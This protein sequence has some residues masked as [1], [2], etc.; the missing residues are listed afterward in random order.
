MFPPTGA[1]WPA[2]WRYRTK[3]GH[4]PGC[5][6]NQEDQGKARRV[7][8]LDYSR[9]WWKSGVKTRFTSR[10]GTTT[11]ATRYQ[12]KP[13]PPGVTPSDQ[14]YKREMHKSASQI[15]WQ[16]DDIDKRKDLA[17]AKSRLGT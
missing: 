1:R 2:G 13:P 14:V 3:Q 11:T 7:G 16:G 5:A 10:S 4:L 8:L 12:S 9:E 17:T 15:A 6:E